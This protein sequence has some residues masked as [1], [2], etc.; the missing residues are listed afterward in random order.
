MKVDF[1]VIVVFET[2]PVGSVNPTVA[3]KFWIPTATPLPVFACV[4]TPEPKL[5]GLVNVAPT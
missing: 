3:P 5:F 4:K 2:Y 1:V